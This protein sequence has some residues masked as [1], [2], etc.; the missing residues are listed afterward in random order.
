MSEFDSFEDYMA[1]KV[2]CERLTVRIEVDGNRIML[3]SY[4]KSAPGYA[5]T[6]ISEK[7][8]DI[9]VPVMVAES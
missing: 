2:S 8:V 6:A 4:L 7:H 1:A 5:A 9:Y 3:E